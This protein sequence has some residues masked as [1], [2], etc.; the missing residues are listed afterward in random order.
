MFTSDYEM[1][2]TMQMIE[3]LEPDKKTGKQQ[4]HIHMYSVH[5]YKPCTTWLKYTCTCTWLY[6]MYFDYILCNMTKLCLVLSSHTTVNV[7]KQKK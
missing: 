1:F 2:D 4:P 3:R 7:L 6:T 5:V